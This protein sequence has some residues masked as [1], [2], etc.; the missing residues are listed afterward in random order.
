M[1]K[2]QTTKKV[3]QGPARKKPAAKRVLVQGKVT[4]SKQTIVTPGDK[5]A[6]VLAATVGGVVVGNMIIPGVGGVLLG[7]I[8]GALLGGSSSKGSKK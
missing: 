7:G 4:Q 1:N 6:Q 8:L 2:R 3:P 5:N